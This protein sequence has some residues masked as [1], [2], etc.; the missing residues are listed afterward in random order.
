M[1]SIRHFAGRVWK[2]QTIPK[3]HFSKQNVAF[4]EVPTDYVTKMD[5]THH[6]PTLK[7]FRV[8]DLQG[9]REIEMARKF[10][11]QGI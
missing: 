7:T 11:R 1:R 2:Y 3:Y 8:I 5:V 6:H 4:R 10:G 9:I